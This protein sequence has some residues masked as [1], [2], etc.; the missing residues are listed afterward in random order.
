[1]IQNKPL[2]R[3]AT[4]DDIGQVVVFL[5]SENSRWVT[6]DVVSTNGGQLMSKIST[7]QG[8]LNDVDIL[9]SGVLHVFKTG[10]DSTNFT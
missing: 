7:T 4:N 5:A 10:K 1:M 8:N 2:K 9:C 6:G 3:I